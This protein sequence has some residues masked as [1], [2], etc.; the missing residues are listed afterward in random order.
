MSNK[1][2]SIE[3]KSLLIVAW[4]WRLERGLTA[5]RLERYLGDD[6]STL[7]MDCG[8]GFITL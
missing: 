1:G 5:N 8:D 6:R 2:K 4:D 3:T 7:K